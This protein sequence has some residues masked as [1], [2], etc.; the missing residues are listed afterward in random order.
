MLILLLLLLLHA[1]AVLNQCHLIH[2]V[3]FALKFTL[4]CYSM[5]VLC[6]RV[7]LHPVFYSVVMKFNTSLNEFFIIVIYIVPSAMDL[8]FRASGT[9]S[10]L[11]CTYLIESRVW[12][13]IKAKKQEKTWS[14][15][16]LSVGGRAPSQLT[17]T[18][19]EKGKGTLDE[20]SLPEITLG[21]FGYFFSVLNFFMCVRVCEY[22]RG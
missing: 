4:R 11:F 17:M 21:N 16:K 13:R 9:G 14:R 7:C 12:E 20:R 22:T 1:S 10:I 2:S 19:S 6:A 15:H 3:S 18:F 8:I 5:R